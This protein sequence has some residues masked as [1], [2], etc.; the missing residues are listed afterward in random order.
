MKKVKD[1]HE[2][3][4]DAVYLYSHPLDKREVNDI[5]LDDQKRIHIVIGRVTDRTYLTPIIEL[6]CNIIVGD[7]YVIYG[8]GII[9][10]T[11]GYKS[12]IY[13]DW[14]RYLFELTEDE[15]LEHFI[16]DKI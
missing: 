11:N 1:I 6:H 13:Y 9:H 5:R 8:D 14:N 4:D 16:W 7:S 3:R 10:K 15:V 2:M 12:T